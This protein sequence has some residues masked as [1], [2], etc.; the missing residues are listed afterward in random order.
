MTKRL[1][2]AGLGVLLFGGG[3]LRS[4]GPAD[5][6][7]EEEGHLI[8]NRAAAE[9]VPAD[10][11]AFFGAASDRLTWLG[12]EPDRWREDS[13]PAL[14]ASQEPDH[15][16]KLELLGEGFEF[17]PDRYAFYRALEGLRADR[18]AAGEDPDAL[19]PE[20]VGLQVYIT[21]EL[22]DRVV[23]AFRQYRDLIAAGEPPEL[24]EGNIILYAGW[25]GHY[26][27][28]GAQ[29]QHT[30][31]QYDGWLGPN[32]NGYSGPGLHYRF[33]GQFVADNITV[34]DIAPLVGPPNRLDDP[35]NDYLDF[36]RSSHELVED[37]FRIDRDGGFTG[38]GTLEGLEFAK[39]RLAA[40]AQ[41]L[42]DLWYTAWLESATSE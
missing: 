26:V 11:P 39:A 13:E 21:I 18:A 24:V 34:E 10:M 40:G 16:V 28:D 42:L 5:A 38:A 6:V 9:H 36:L 22:Y 31:V 29:P 1:L 7:W 4:S 41:M 17:S 37:V 12:P 32:P 19:L 25:L 2:L 20:R 30:S 35:V 15:F 8:V 3:A 14:K 23:V 33:E 27:A